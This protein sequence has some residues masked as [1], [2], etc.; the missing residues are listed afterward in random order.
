MCS[1]HSE[2]RTPVC[3]SVRKV[4]KADKAGERSLE[5]VTE[6]ARIAKVCSTVCILV[7]A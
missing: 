4:F 6:L 7:L 1:R 2:L 3:A 5:I